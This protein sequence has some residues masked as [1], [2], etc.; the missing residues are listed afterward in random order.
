[1]KHV[2][3]SSKYQIV[4]PKEIREKLG[5]QAGAKVLLIP[6]EDRV[7]MILQQDIKNMRGVLKGMD[8]TIVRE[9]AERK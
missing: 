3:I 6:Y 5:W 1:M 7:E 2:S 4:I 9:R 8:T